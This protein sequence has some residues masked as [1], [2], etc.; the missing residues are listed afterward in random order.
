MDF[1]QQKAIYLQIAERI[2]D[3][4]LTGKYPE[5]G[6]IPSVREY[7]AMVEVNFNTVMRSFEYLQL[8]KIIYNKRGVGYFV[9]EGAKDIVLSTRRD[10]FLENELNDFFRNIYVLNISMEEI[11][12]MYSN[13]VKLKNNNSNETNN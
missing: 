4:I 13:Y 10:K 5:D 7:A 6:R 12:E 1:K 11:T 9:A 3:E 8:K 2:C